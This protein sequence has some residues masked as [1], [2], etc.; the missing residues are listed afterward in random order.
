MGRVQG[1]GPRK[2]GAIPWGQIQVL[3]HK[4]PT[5]T[6]PERAHLDSSP[7]G[8]SNPGHLPPCQGSGPGPSTKGRLKE[9]TMAGQAQRQHPQPGHQWPKGPP[10]PPT[11]RKSLQTYREVPVGAVGWPSYRAPLR[12]PQVHEDGLPCSA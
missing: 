2:G 1:E 6:T 3:G 9:G 8:D 5:A 7:A 4:A 11:Q 10:Q 12:K